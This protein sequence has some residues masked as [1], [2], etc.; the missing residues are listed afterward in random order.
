MLAHERQELIL[1]I[2]KKTHSIRIGEISKQFGVSIETAR[3][4]LDY[5]QNRGHVRR[6]HGGAVLVQQDHTAPPP[7]EAK[8][9]KNSPH[10]N[11]FQ[12]AAN[13]VHDGNTLFIGHG[14]TMYQF[15]KNLA[16]KSNLTVFTNSL[17]VINE[18]VGGKSSVFALGGMVD[19]DESNMNGSIPIYVAQQFF[20]DKA[21]ISCGGISSTGEVSDY[22]CDT[23]LMKVMLKQA[24][25]K[26]LI[27]DSSK[28]G[29]TTFGRVCNLSDF[30]AI[31]TDANLP[32]SYQEMI[33]QCN[34]DL[35]RSNP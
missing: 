23:T 33:Q 2:V 21:F 18:M 19:P 31:I 9:S 14:S 6:T 10:N 17:L 34:I 5:L 16:E 24:R 4:D 8:V 28:F 20:I 27:A 7:Q 26:Y 12:L 13:F 30:D 29:R 11:L 25:K 3:R 32:Q 1:E 22:H 15:S 35:I